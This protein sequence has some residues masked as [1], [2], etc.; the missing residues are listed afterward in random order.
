[1]SQKYI[2]SL[3]LVLNPIIIHQSQEFKKKLTLKIVLFPKFFRN[4]YRI[5]ILDNDKRDIFSLVLRIISGIY[6]IFK[7]IY[8]SKQF[9]PRTN[10]WLVS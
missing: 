5:K 2:L 7:K 3:T 8:I 6:T 4:V 9:L 10:F 1:M